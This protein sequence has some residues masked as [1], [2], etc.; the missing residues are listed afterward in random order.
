LFSTWIG[1]SGVASGAEARLLGLIDAYDVK[2]IAATAHYVTADLDEGPIIEQEVARVD[3]RHDPD[4]LVMLGC[5][6]EARALS[7][8]VRWHVQHRILLNGHSTVVFPGM[9]RIPEPTR[10]LR[11]PPPPAGVRADHVGW[12]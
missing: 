12:W 3:H 11:D 4:Q 7:R 10:P 8:A 2:Q 5:D 1:V 9:R 6:T